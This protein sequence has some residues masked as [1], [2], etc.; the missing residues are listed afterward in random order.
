MADEL[1][2]TW[3][4]FLREQ[5]GPLTEALKFKT[6]LLA[7]VKRDKNPTRWAG[8][9]VTVPIINAPQQGASMITENGAL[10]SPQVLDHEQAVIKSAIIEL[11]VS[12]STQLLEQAKND[13]T[14]WAQVVPTKMRMAEN[15]ISRV[16]NEQMCGQGDAL[17]AAVTGTTAASG[18]ANQL[19]TVGTGANFYQLYAG[20]VADVVI[21]ATGAVGTGLLAAKIN[22]YS[23]SGGTVQFA[24]SFAT[25][26]TYGI[27]IQGSWGNALQGVGQAVATTGVFEGVNKTN[28]AV[29]RGLDASPAAASDPTM[30]ILDSAERKAMQFGGSTPDFYLC[31]PA[32]AD[33]YQ[34]GLSAQAR[35]DGSTAKLSTGFVGI[36]YRG[37]VLLS[38]FDMPPKTIYG[39]AKDDMTIYTL[40][41]GPDW[42]E[43]DGS[44]FKRFSRALPVE[45]WLVWMLQLGFHRCNGFVK[46]G[47]LNQAA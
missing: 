27:Y 14:A 15:A 13:D 5:K 32:V 30:A 28:I 20:R 19:V 11:A 34:Q 24:G 44:M 35:W 43:K 8:K 29:W 25:D 36:E 41:D 16:I 38:E 40:D 4:D 3:A 45:A 31:D 22:D 26:N 46:I 42:D 33:K 17:I 10:T 6:V 9:Q 21:R 2:T 23:V 1:T 18:G 12:F 7:E 47:S 37:K 39:I